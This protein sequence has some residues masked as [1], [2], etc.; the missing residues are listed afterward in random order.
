MRT[1]LW[2][3]IG[4]RGGSNGLAKDV[5]TYLA[6]VKQVIIF[7]S[8]LDGDGMLDKVLEQVCMLHQNFQ[9][10]LKRGEGVSM[11]S[12]IIIDVCSYLP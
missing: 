6:L 5:A 4:E 7:R 9:G 12:E 10:R 8:L 2:E 1:W 11:K 3:G